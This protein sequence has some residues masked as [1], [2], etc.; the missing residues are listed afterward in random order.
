MT[1]VI[2]RMETYGEGDWYVALCPELGIS[3][4]GKTPEDAKSD[5]QEAVGSY[6]RECEW[7]GIL[8]GV[9][10]DSGFKKGGDMWRLA[11]RSVEEK[12]AAIEAGSAE[13]P[14]DCRPGESGYT[15]TSKSGVSIDVRRLSKEDVRQKLS[16]LEKKYGM[17]SLEFVVKYRTG[18][19]KDHNLDFFDW[20]F[21]YDSAG[22]LG[23][24]E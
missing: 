22:G 2:Y 8:S 16:E 12:V 1:K 13:K 18:K 9:L 19:F 20:E 21:Y 6:L 23:L 10:E 14:G 11:G 3:R 24:L 4:S 5:V 15:Y 17:T 7:Q